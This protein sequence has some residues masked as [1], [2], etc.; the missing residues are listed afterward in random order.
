VR[1]PHQKRFRLIVE[2]MRGHKRVGLNTFCQ[3]EEQRISRIARS[4]LQSIRRLLAGPDDR[5]MRETER[6][7]KL[8][9][10]HSLAPRVW[11]EPVI[12]RRND[13]L[14]A[15]A[16]SLA[17]SVYEMEKRGRIRPARHGEQHTATMFQSGE[18]RIEFKI[19]E[20][21]TARLS[22]GHAFV[23]ARPRAS[24]WPKPWDIS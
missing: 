17:P 1:E 6:A 3:P 15:D 2:R 20:R 14:G 8:L 11:P 24:H 5:M 18:I 12:D 23:P 9:D 19:G 4:F 13:E 7:R 22:S 21:L 10:V 16:P